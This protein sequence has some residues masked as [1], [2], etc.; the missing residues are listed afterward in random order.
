MAVVY[1]AIQR[2]LNRYVAIKV[3]PIELAPDAARVHRFRR[4]AA[5]IAALSHP[6]ILT[7][8]DFGEDEGALYFVTEYIE[9][10]T[11]RDRL[12][13]PFDPAYAGVILSQVGRALDH[14][15]ASGILHRDVKPAN[16]LL[17]TPDWALLADF[18]IAK[19]VEEQ[20]GVTLTG[21]TIGTAEYM[22]PEQAQ[23]LPLDRG[24]DIYSLG[25]VAY[26]MLTGA[27]P[28]RASS[29]M[30]VGIRH[31][32]EPPRPPHELN[33][34]IS[35]EVEAV[36]L[37]ALSKRPDERYGT[38]GA[39]ARAYAAA[40]D[41]SPTAEV[42]PSFGASA[43]PNLT[44]PT[45]APGMRPAAL[46]PVWLWGAFASV[47]LLAAIC[48]ASLIGGLGAG[49]IAGRGEGGSAPTSVARA[50]T[51]APRGVGDDAPVSPTANIAAT[52]A[53]R[54]AE[55]QAA[56]TGA[57]ASRTAE[58]RT[59]E[60]LSLQATATA[61]SLSTAQA[62]GQATAAAIGQA[63][64]T[65]IGQATA[66]AFA[67]AQATTE[68]RL[69]LRRA[70]WARVL[71]NDPN[72]VHDGRQDSSDFGTFVEVKGSRARGSVRPEDISFGDVDGDGREEAALNLIFPIGVRTGGALIYRATESGPSL[73]AVVEPHDT[74]GVKVEGGKLMVAE[75]IYAESDPG[76]CP[77]GTRYLTY[78]LAGRELVL[79]SR[80]ED[81]PPG[82]VRPATV[83]RYYS[84]INERRFREAYTYVG[85][86]FRANYPLD[87]W[88]KG[89]EAL[90]SVTA[91]AT[92]VSPQGTVQV[93]LTVVDRTAAGQITR[94]FRGTWGLTRGGVG[95]PWILDDPNISELR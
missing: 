13:G 17:Q 45:P 47:A 36:I 9:G 3:L 34:A 89:H 85:P 75:G 72:L 8:H 4:E 70:N 5:A 30:A 82:V 23:G 27:V 55:S 6:N 60:G 53:A 41:V 88:I 64:A 43:T 67:I 94:R 15:H 37:R 31:V 58:A 65:A 14:A 25:V 51:A 33:P 92:D 16:I 73:A 20:E 69:D 78:S 7:I 49:A 87:E 50:P 52:A 21:M 62:Y 11:L 56:A 38:A 66:T 74:L 59:V 61:A 46:R 1:K 2:S 91:K 79:V 24:T 71:S 40:L 28:F 19:I 76:C 68:A 32:N 63:T 39:F 35:P 48:A 26:H 81:G 83:V 54:T 77:S 18:G 90:V 12:T 86:R 95:Q 57:A 10:G 93:E 29:P 44:V 22:S 84:L 80:A 42:P